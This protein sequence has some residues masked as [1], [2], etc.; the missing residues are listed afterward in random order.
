[1]IDTKQFVI[2][3]ICN[4]PF[5]YLVYQLTNFKENQDWFKEEEDKNNIDTGMNDKGY[6]AMLYRAEQINVDANLVISWDHLSMNWM[7][8]WKH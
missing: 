8:E 2:I 5:Y 3:K 1:M 4:R 6:V 7:K